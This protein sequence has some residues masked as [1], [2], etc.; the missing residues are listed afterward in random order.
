MFHKRPQMSLFLLPRHDDH[1][2]VNIQ[3]Y[4]EIKHATA[5][6]GETSVKY[7]FCDITKGWFPELCVLSGGKFLRKT[8]SAVYVIE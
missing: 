5:N 2:R 8:Q 1:G 7:H 3:K 6:L 4:S